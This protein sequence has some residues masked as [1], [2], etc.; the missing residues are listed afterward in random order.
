MNSAYQPFDGIPAE[1]LPEQ[2]PTEGR[3]QGRLLFQNMIE[4]LV[5]RGAQRRC[6]QAVFCDADF[7]DWPLGA[8]AVA[9]ALNVWARAGCRFTFIAQQYDEITRRHAR[10]VEWRRRW[11]HQVDCWQCANIAASSLPSSVWTDEWMLHRIDPVR[12]V[13][14]F[15]ARCRSSNRDARDDRSVVARVEARISCDHARPLN[16]ALHVLAQLYRAIYNEF[17]SSGHPMRQ[18]RTDLVRTT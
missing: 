10:W 13:F 4:Q 2:T 14:F 3:L 17:A 6:R 1:V 9:S 8:C 18:H 5:G 11:S 15:S 7:A 12:S 16:A